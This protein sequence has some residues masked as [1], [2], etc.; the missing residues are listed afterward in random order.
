MDVQT[1]STDPPPNEPQS[2]GKIRKGFKLFGKRK[3]G[4]IFSIRS[5]G[6]GNNKSPV[7]RSQTSDG[8]SETPA[9]DSEQEPD[10]EKRQEVSQGETEQT[11]D[12]T[13]REDAILAAAPARTSIS[14]VS[15]ARSLS[16]LSL[17]RGSRRGVGDRRVQT[18]SQPVARQRRGLKGLFGNVKSRL[19]DKNDKQE[20]P[21]SPILR[22]SRANSVEIIKE[23]LTLTPK[24]QPRSLDSPET[25]VSTTHDGAAKPSSVTTTPKM[26]TANVSKT[27]EYV[28]PLPTSE[29]PL[30]PDDNSLT[31]LLADISS[32]LT[33]D[34]I[35]GGGDIIADVEAEWGKASKAIDAAVTNVNPSS[36]SFISKTTISSPPASTTTKP[37]FSS[38]MTSPSTTLTTSTESSFISESVKLKI[39][40]AHTS[41][42]NKAELAPSATTTKPL[43]SPVMMTN[44]PGLS[45]SS[46]TSQSTPSST[47]APTT[48]SSSTL[49]SSAPT[50]AGKRFADITPSPQNIASASKTVT[51][52]TSSPGSMTHNPAVA[53]TQPPPLKLDSVNCLNLQKTN[54]FKPSQ[55]AAAEGPK[56]PDTIS[57]TCTITAKPSTSASIVSSKITTVPTSSTTSDS[58]FT[59]PS[60][61]SLSTTLLDSNKTSATVSAPHP[62]STLTTAN[63]AQPSPA[64][65]PVHSSAV[66]KT[67]PTIKASTS[68]ASTDKTSSPPRLIPETA[69]HAAS[70]QSLAPTALSQ[71]TGCHS[72]ASSAQIPNSV[73]KAQGEVAQSK[74]IPTT[75]QVSD[76]L[77]K[78]LPA[79]VKMQAA[80]LKESSVPTQTSVS[81]ACKYS[82]APETTATSSSKDPV[83]PTQSAVFK[84]PDGPALSFSKESSASVSIPVSL[85]KTASTSAQITVSQPSAN[86]PL[87][88]IT[89]ICP[90]APGMSEVPLSAKM[91]ASTE[92]Q[93][94]SPDVVDGDRS[95]ASLSKTRE[96]LH[97]PRTELQQP[98]KEKKPTSVKASGLSKIPVVGGG[99]VVKIPVRE[100]QYVNDES[101]RDPPTPIMEERPHFN[102]HE[103]S[104]GST[105]EASTPTSKIPVKH[106]AQT[107]DAP[108]TKIPVSKVPVRRAGNKPAAAGG[109]SQPHSVIIGVG[110]G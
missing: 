41:T 43:T 89:S 34:S 14:S 98:P 63:K 26:K 96:P 91:R 92:Y 30:V 4:N 47:S 58:V 40:S 3:P 53:V 104:K 15:S 79:F 103:A 78:D 90:P 109:G 67:L 107:K 72:Q 52:T 29:P 2:S 54:S 56:S 7:L 23:D 88:P 62:S 108:R 69:T 50:S 33:F 39:D 6:D 45:S 25:D 42:S 32:L 81:N 93:L 65:A 95:Q 97:E 70:P 19:K 21:P 37:I 28:S 59:A 80:P 71:I 57:T 5:K 68:P 84:V 102:S 17:L 110:G 87:C 100:S 99:R 55:S 36:M 74:L 94:T 11:E 101:S 8:F 105:T 61:P 9:P 35:S 12:E 27:N 31:S 64:S 20:V 38:A 82:A 51:L 86:L 60:K 44:F 77:P 48:A 13:L 73:S 10:K 75:A 83:A 76:S 46:K 106:G 1:E 66:D 85:P 18:V 49:V 16:F 24:C 22:S